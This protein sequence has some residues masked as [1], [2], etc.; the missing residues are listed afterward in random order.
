MDQEISNDEEMAS[1]ESE[2]DEAHDTG[3]EDA[4]EEEW[5]G[6]DEGGTTGMGGEGAQRGGKPKKPPTGEEVRAIKEA[7]DLFRSSS[8]K[9]QVYPV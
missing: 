2:E 9:F 5:D 4:E 6:M 3:E 8:F 1:R 7:T